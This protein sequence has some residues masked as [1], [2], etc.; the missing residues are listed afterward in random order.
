MREQTPQALLTI[1]VDWAPDFMI[2]SLA[3]TLAGA[4]VRSTWFVTHASEAIDELRRRPDMYELG[5]HP[6]FLAGSSHGQTPEEVIR[7]CMDLVPEAVC[8]R[9]HSLVQSTRLLETVVRL[10]PVRV[11]LSLFLPGIP[12]IGPLIQHVASPLLVRVPYSWEDDDEMARPVPCWDHKAHLRVGGPVIFDFHPVHVFL[13]SSSMQAY[14][15]LKSK[16]G[17]LDDLSERETAGY[18]NPEAGTGTMFRALVSDLRSQP[19]MRVSDLFH[20]A[21]VIR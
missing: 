10:S 7:H 8:M 15:A 21:K 13:N 14:N 11:D 9:T 4:S 1:D 16:T 12:A 18:V 6:N 5:I 2:R 19:S 20:P 3:N 17:S